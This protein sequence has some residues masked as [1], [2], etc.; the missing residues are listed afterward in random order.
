M[1]LSSKNDIWLLHPTPFPEQ[2]R[3]VRLASMITL[4]N[5]WWFFK[6]QKGAWKL[7]LILHLDTSASVPVPFQR[8]TLR[9]EQYA[10]E[11]VPGTCLSSIFGFEPSKRSPFPIKTGAFGFYIYNIY[12]IYICIRI[13][14]KII[15]GWLWKP[16]NLRWNFHVWL[17]G[18]PGTGALLS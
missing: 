15:L 8:D 6:T 16:M 7:P 14:L 4:H 9:K 13:H 5:C 11:N 17:T 3:P 12:N 1:S 18:Q 2:S 10:C